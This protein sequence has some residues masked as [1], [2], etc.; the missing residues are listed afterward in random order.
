MMGFD[1]ML[2]EVAL[3]AVMLTLASTSV[4]AQSK[5]GCQSHCGNISIPYPFGTAN[6][7]NISSDFFVRCDTTLDP[8]K[9]FL[10]LAQPSMILPGGDVLGGGDAEVQVLHISLDGY[11]RISSSGN[12]GSACYS[13]SGHSPYTQS[14]SGFAAYLYELVISHT[15]NKLTAIGCDTII[16]ISSFFQGPYFNPQNFSTGCLTFCG[17]FDDVIGGSCS[18]IGCCQTAIPK[19]L[20]GYEY[21]FDSRE[22]HSS[23]LSF[24]PCSYGFVVEDGAYNFSVSDLNDTNFSK[25]EFPLILDWTIGRQNCTE[26]QRDPQNY[27]CKA[28][29]A[30]IDPDNNDGYLCKCVDG[31]KGNPYLGCQD[32]NECETL[33]PCT[34]VGTCH[35][36]PG[37]YSCSCP[38]G[39][40]GDGWKNGTGCTQTKSSPDSPLILAL[41]VLGSSLGLLVLIAGV[42][43]LY[44]VL[45]RRKNIKLKQKLFER[46]GGLLFQ[47]KLSSNEGGLDKAKLFSSKELEAATDQYNENRILGRGGQGMVYKGMLPDGR[48]VAVKKSMTVNQGFLEQFINE[49]VIL[50]Q[51][52]HRNVVKLLGCCLET[53][54]PLLVYEFIPNGTLSHFIHDQNEEYPRSWDIRLRIA[55]EV[56]SAISYLHSSASVPIYHRDIK[57]SNILLDEKFRAKVSDF[58]TS[59]SVG[60]DQTHLTTQVLGTFGYLDPEYF[61]SSQFTEKSDV[62]SFGV[63]IVELLTGQKAVS[64]LGSEE[65]RGL[66]SYFMTAMEE[67]RLPDIVD[68]EIVK[69]G[70]K[71]EVVA[72]AQLSKRCLNL[73]GRLRPTMKEV[74]MELERL[75]TWQGDCIPIDQPTQSDLVVRKS[76]ET[77]SFSTEYYTCGIT[78]TSQADVR[79][80][81]LDT[82]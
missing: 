29:S 37:S 53:E 52:D 4:A 54:V 38:E 23:V 65:M 20:R 39:F 40:E 49:I 74:A 28:H 9:P 33:K 45:E 77:T 43:K 24:N 69:D 1:R 10:T 32:I 3:F 47:K 11:V 17:G 12:I 51:I 58:G 78:S 18:G 81:M 6:G 14:V 41:L 7:C 46:N 55:A 34:S 75:R 21:N 16:Y 26:A 71:D 13:S 72:V 59:R 61:Q 73:D 56:A 63:V 57:S 62:Y 48:I 70:L 50:S 15:R 19:G 5:P 31:F 66:V 35:N 30:C 82:I 76:N 8:P 60:F 44:K 64:K 42:W 67:N 80:L 22:N 79:P 68:G 36:T 25:R 27:A 2:T